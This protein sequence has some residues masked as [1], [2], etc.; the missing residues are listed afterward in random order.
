[1]IKHRNKKN[2]G[3]AASLF[4]YTALCFMIMAV[5]TQRDNFFLLGYTVFGEKER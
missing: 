4:L 3:R 2:A 1:M 5:F